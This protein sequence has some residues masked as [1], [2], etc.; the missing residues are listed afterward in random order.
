[1]IPFPGS[2]LFRYLARIYALNFVALWVLLIGVVSLFDMIELLRRAAK[3][4]DVGFSLVFE[5]A[6]LKTPEMAMVIAP[7]VV[8]FSALFTFW[9]LARRQELVVLRSS[10]V[11][12]W[13][14]LSPVVAVSMIVGVFIFSILDPVSAVFYGRYDHLEKTHLKREADSVVALFDEGMWLKQTTSE[15]H[16]ILHAGSIEL[17]E[18]RLHDVMVLFFDQKDVFSERLDASSAQL[19]SGNWLLKDAVLNIP[20]HPLKKSSQ[21]KIP[22]DL[23]TQDIEESFS[24]PQT[25]G[26]WVLPSYIDTLENTGFDS[27]RLRIHFQQLLALPFLFG[28]MVFLAACV[29]MRPSRQGGGVTFVLIGVVAGFVVF[30]LSNFLQA[31]GSSHQLPIFLAAWSPALLSTLVGVSVLLTLEDG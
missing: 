10:G 23:T 29:A 12:V 16:A 31:L 13:Q 26:F 8:L 2:T 27:T 4:D 21:A 24:A 22:T 6:A 17:P 30:F 25:M 9:Q 18:W 14:F 7:F 5:M 28:S 20:G 3:V 19:K 11:S 15:G 1:M